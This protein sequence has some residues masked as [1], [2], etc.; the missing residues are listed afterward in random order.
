MAASE[1]PSPTQRGHFQ[2]YMDARVRWGAGGRQILTAPF[3]TGGVPH[4]S[5]QSL[6]AAGGACPL[7]TSVYAGGELAETQL[8]FF[9]QDPHQSAQLLSVPA[10]LQAFGPPTPPWTSPN[11]T[12]PSGPRA[13]V[14]FSR[15]P[16]GP[17]LPP[18]IGIVLSCACIR[19]FSSPSPVRCNDP[20]NAHRSP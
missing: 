12:H 10:F 5:H 7:Q 13:D 1:E 11:P 14:P 16:G 18:S 15:K 20:F 4:L 2:S 3:L 17:A 19:T 8:E 6:A 9:L